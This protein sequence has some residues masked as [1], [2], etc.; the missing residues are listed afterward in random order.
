[1]F[2]IQQYEAF[3]AIADTIF[4]SLSDDVAEDLAKKHAEY[5]ALYG[6]QGIPGPTSQDIAMFAK[7]S[8][9]DVFVTDEVERLLTTELPRDVRQKLAIV[10]YLLTT[11]IGTKLITGSRAVPYAQLSFKEREEALLR[12]AH[13]QI[14][15]VRMLF[16]VILNYNIIIEFHNLTI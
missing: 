9:S 10:L 8:A 14:P 15:L 3:K 5:V 7:A 1:M 4:P 12:L 16:K 13:S 11:S 6:G 2:S